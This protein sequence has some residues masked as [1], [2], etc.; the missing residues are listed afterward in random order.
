MK[1]GEDRARCQKADRSDETLQLSP[2]VAQVE[3]SSAEIGKS[4]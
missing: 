2:G 3:Q 4:S 1:V